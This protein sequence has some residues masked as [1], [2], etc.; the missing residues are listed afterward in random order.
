MKYIFSTVTVIL[1]KCGTIPLSKYVQ[2]D[3]YFLILLFYEKT[4]RSC[5]II[6]IISYIQHINKRLRL[7][8]KSLSCRR[9]FKKTVVSN[10]LLFNAVA[11]S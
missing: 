8:N 9:E 4:F 1:F 11:I 3:L 5:R 7:A 10:I 6:G 2:M